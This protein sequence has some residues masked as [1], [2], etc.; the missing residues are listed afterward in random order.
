MSTPGQ[1][2]SAPPLL[3]GGEASAPQSPGGL[4][5]THAVTGGT[6]CFQKP[7]C[8]LLKTL[9]SSSDEVYRASHL[10]DKTP[11][12]TNP[13]ALLK[14]SFYLKLLLMSTISSRWRHRE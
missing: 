9:L 14:A 12:G 7:V 4:S 8:T 10:Q 13:F 2:E 11:N 5:G 1:S 6:M 3:E